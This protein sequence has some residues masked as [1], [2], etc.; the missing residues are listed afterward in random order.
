MTELIDR[1][2]YFK[3]WT[4]LANE[5]NR[6]NMPNL[7]ILLQSISNTRISP[8][9]Q[10]NKKSIVADATPVTEGAS[11]LKEELIP[12]LVQ[13]RPKRVMLYCNWLKSQDLCLLWSKMSKNGDM[14]WGNIEIV[15]NE[16]V[17]YYVVINSPPIGTPELPKHKTL[18]FQ[19]EPQMAM[20]PVMWGAWANPSPKEW[21]YVSRHHD[22][23][24]N[25]EWHLGKTY[26]QLMNEVIVKDE[27]L[28]G[29][30]SAVLSSKYIDVGH[31]K[32]VDFVKFTE[33]AQINNQ[34]LLVPFHVFGDNTFLWKNYKG[35]LP[36]HCKNNALFP[37]KYTFNAENY[38]GAG[39]FTEKLIDGILT[40]TLVFYW[41]C[42]NVNQWIDE[43]AFV[44][45]DLNDFDASLKIIQQAIAEDW[46][47]QRLPYIKKAKLKVLNELQFFPRLD[48]II[49][50]IENKK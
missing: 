38:D 36:Y 33:Q 7:G 30:V 41:G 29:I 4:K 48:R 44:R 2:V 9:E 6:V 24:N 14:K 18:I 40:E 32:R 47:T 50:T 42:F 43:K 25:I 27:A 28:S 35:T 15:W 1:F 23:H 5:C 37:Y 3:D 17:D 16:P 31:I 21:A 22:E 8:S 46:Y 12:E 45:L 19:M 20:R 34:G 39:Y 10:L 11:L 26:Q 13:V 49:H